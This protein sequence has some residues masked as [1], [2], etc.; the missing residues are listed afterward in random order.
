MN[1][2]RLVSFETVYPS[3]IKRQPAKKILPYILIEQIQ[4]AARST[5]LD[6]QEPVPVLRNQNQLLIG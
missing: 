5:I 6:L 4:Q 1:C 2:C 3:P